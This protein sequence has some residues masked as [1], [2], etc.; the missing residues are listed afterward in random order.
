MGT[1]GVR[2]VYLGVG[3][4]WRCP[5]DGDSFIVVVDVHG[6]IGA[7]NTDK[8]IPGMTRGQVLDIYLDQTTLRY[9]TT[10]TINQLCDVQCSPDQQIG[11]VDI[12]YIVITC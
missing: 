2:V 1:G 10:P 11:S 4:S 12:G 5:K 6:D 3:G 9:I 8:S 7:A